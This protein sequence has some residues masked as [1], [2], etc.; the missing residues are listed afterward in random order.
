MPGSETSRNST[1][2][3]V[4]VGGLENS[5]GP[6]DWSLMLSSSPTTREKVR[7][8]APYTSSSPLL[9]AP[10]KSAAKIGQAGWQM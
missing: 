10:R 8:G 7:L 9:Q 2:E 6:I 1:A 3:P 4:S 5:P